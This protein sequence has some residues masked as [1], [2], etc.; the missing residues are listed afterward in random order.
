VFKENGLA[1]APDWIFASDLETMQGFLARMTSTYG[2][3]EEWAL[4]NGIT[5]V[6]IA[7]LRAS[8]LN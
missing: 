7:A 1:Y 3:A 5:S 8:L 4:A 6:Q 2:G